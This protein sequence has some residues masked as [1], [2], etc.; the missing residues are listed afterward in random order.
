MDEALTP[1]QRIKRARVMKMKSNIIAKKRARAMK[2]R[3]PSE[4][5]QKRSMK[6]AREILTKKILN[7]KSKSD[8]GY[9]ELENLE[10]KLDKKKAVIKKIAKKMLPQLKKAEKER[11]EKLR[12]SE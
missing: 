5:I 10:K 11:I 7:N 9:G 8:L 1:A 2:K 4:V 3:A 6:K 12:S